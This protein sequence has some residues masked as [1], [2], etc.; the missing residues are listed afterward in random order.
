MSG[1][2]Q[3]DERKRTTEEVSKSYGRHQNWGLTVLQDKPGGNLFT[4]WAVSGI[5]VA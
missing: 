3:A 1:E 4:A 5:K 2:V